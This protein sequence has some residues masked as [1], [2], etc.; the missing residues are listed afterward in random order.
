MVTHEEVLKIARLAKLYIDESELDKLTKD[1]S[2]SISFADTISQAGDE[3][4][5][6]DNINNLQNAFRQ[7]QVVPSYPREEILKNANDQEDGY[8][9]VRKRQ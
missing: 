4:T 9:A 7:D 5:G 6:F 3:A 1:M 2:E 8:F